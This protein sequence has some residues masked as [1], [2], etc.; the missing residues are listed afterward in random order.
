M[1]SIEGTIL[2]AAAYLNVNDVLAKK[3][4]KYLWLV[5]KTLY[6]RGSL[7]FMTTPRAR[8]RGRCGGGGSIAF[9]RILRVGAKG[10]AGPW[11]EIVPL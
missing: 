11:G 9:V 2:A 3:S 10:E 6:E 7:R 8:S 1:W 4:G 5:A